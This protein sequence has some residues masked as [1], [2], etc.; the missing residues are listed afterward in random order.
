[1]RRTGRGGGGCRNE[2]TVSLLG[3]LNCIP[4]GLWVFLGQETGNL[5]VLPYEIIG[6]INDSDFVEEPPRS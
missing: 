2:G 5:V 6:A 4:L 1:M 3:S